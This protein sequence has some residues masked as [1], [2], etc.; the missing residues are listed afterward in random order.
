MG[1]YFYQH[2]FHIQYN[3]CYKNY[4]LLLV[5]ITLLLFKKGSYIFN[6]VVSEWKSSLW[7]YKLILSLPRRKSNYNVEGAHISIKIGGTITPCPLNFENVQ[8]AEKAVIKD[9]FG[10]SKTIQSNLEMVLINVCNNFNIRFQASVTSSV[11]FTFLSFFGKI[12]PVLTNNPLFL[13]HFFINICK[14]QENIFPNFISKI[15]T[16][17]GLLGPKIAHIFFT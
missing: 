13:A 9:C 4:I 5:K 1:F 6:F 11:C 7:H 2:Y 16:E 10:Q 12:Y 8:N 3:Y 15:A 14:T 17:S